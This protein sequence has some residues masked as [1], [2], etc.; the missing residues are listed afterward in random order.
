MLLD[1]TDDETILVQAMARCF[2]AT[3][4]YLGQ[5]WYRSPLSRNGL[6]L[7][8]TTWSENLYFPFSKSSWSMNITVR[9]S[10]YIMGSESVCVCV[11]H[12]SCESLCTHAY[13]LWA[14]LQ[15]S[16]WVHIWNLIS[17]V[18]KPPVQ[19]NGF[20]TSPSIIK[21][22]IQISKTSL[23]RNFILSEF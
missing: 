17:W 2:Q 15:S 8:P 5:C 22:T 20:M 21:T 11:G 19:K 16:I 1:P 7:Q 4:H 9:R 14:K 3:S 12:T 23:W 18:W 13:F 6:K 10:Q